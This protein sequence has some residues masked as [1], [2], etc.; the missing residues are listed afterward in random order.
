MLTQR[1]DVLDSILG[2]LPRETT[3]LQVS[4][5]IST[6]RQMCRCCGATYFRAA[7]GGGPLKETLETYIK[8]FQE[9]DLKYL[10]V[11]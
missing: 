8:N 9:K 10:K 3:V 2:Q 1:P 5:M 6:D 11:V 7:E 4:I